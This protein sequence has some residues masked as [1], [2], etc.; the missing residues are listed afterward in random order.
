[1]SSSPETGSTRA[2]KY[3]IIRFLVSDLYSEVEIEELFE[4]L[5]SRGAIIQRRT[6]NPAWHDLLLP[7]DMDVIPYYDALEACESIAQAE[8]RRALRYMIPVTVEG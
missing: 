1:M 5:E 6:S 4:D 3:Q 2:R 8:I 7:A